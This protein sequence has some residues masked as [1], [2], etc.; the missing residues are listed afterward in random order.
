MSKSA[1]RKATAYSNGRF[2]DSVTVHTAPSGTQYVNP[3]DVFFTKEQ[4][5]RYIEE[6]RE[7]A[8]ASQAQR[9]E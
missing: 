8:R 2:Q 7:E 6:A 5:A 1:Y 3:I 9:T 4:V